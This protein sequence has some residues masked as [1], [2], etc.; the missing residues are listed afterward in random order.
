[1]KISKINFKDK[2]GK[3]STINLSRQDGI[4][5]DIFFIYG[6]PNSGK[7]HLCKSISDA[8]QLN[9][10]H[11]ESAVGMNLNKAD[12]SIHGAF[13][14]MQQINFGLPSSMSGKVLIQKKVVI[15][16]S[17]KNSILYYPWNRHTCVDENKFYGEIVTNASLPLIDLSDNTITNCCLLVDNA[18]RGFTEHETSEYIVEISQL[19]SKNDNQVI[20][21][22]D[23]MNCGKIVGSNRS[24][25]MQELSTS[26]TMTICR[27]VVKNTRLQK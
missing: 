3:N 4:I 20:M 13:N 25:S 7:T 2:D 5:Y 19:A 10:F 26:S 14:D 21:F 8:W 16:S 27:E 12:I 17:I 9:M 1:M 18:A 22:V 24:Y 23:T 15:D 11:G 6:P